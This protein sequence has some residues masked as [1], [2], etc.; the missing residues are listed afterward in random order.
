MTAVVV[1][2]NHL[3]TGKSLVTNFRKHKICLIMI[4]N[5]FFQVLCGIATYALFSRVTSLPMSRH[6]I[7]LVLEGFLDTAAMFY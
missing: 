7:Y 4:M 1:T 6:C 3:P 5:N 2:C